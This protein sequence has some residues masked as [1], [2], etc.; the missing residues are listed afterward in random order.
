M[1]PLGEQDGFSADRDAVISRAGLSRR[2]TRTSGEVPAYPHI[3]ML[4]NLGV[5]RQERRRY[6][7]LLAEIRGI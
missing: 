6:K 5:S 3:E 4:S 1:R 2:A 7:Q